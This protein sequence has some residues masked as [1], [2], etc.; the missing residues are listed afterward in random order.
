MQDD[1]RYD[2]VVAEVRRYLAAR[3]AALV[4]ARHRARARWRVDPGIG[5]GKTVE[6]NLQ[7][8]ARPGRAGCAGACRWWSGLSR[9]SFLGSSRGA[10]WTNGWP[11]AWRRCAGAALHGAHVMRV[12]DVTESRRCGARC[13]G[14][15]RH[16]DGEERTVWTACP[17]VRRQRHVP[18]P[19][20]GAV[21]LLHLPVLPRHARR[22]GPGRVGRCCSS[23][24]IGLTQVFNLDALNWLLRRLSVFLARGA[25][26][27]LPA[28]DPARPGRAGQA[29]GLRRL[30]GEA[31]A[32]STT[33]CR[34]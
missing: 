28:R 4:A 5:F 3:V 30:G 19:R 9:K 6:H 26:D 25:A 17:V 15:A 32:W 33:S 8:L 12:H 7:L 16:V 20:P 2:D 18:G 31:H 21:L 34:P 11:A 10:R 1:P 24:L 29:A 22:P 23:I 13:D 27:H 14:A